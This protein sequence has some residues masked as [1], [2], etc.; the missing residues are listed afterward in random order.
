[1]NCQNWV[2]VIRERDLSEMETSTKEL[3]IT[4]I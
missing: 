4:F 3:D 2:V 1:M